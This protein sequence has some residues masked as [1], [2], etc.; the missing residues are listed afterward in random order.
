M[1][2]K[3]FYEDN[4][5][6]VVSEGFVKK[7]GIR[8]VNNK[9]HLYIEYTIDREE[10]IIPLADIRLAFLF[11]VETMYEFFRYEK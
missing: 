8:K 2:L 6:I 11:D 5:G 7:V 3:V 1:N 9:N 10:S 4:E